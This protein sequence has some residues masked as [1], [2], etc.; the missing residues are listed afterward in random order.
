[1]KANVSSLLLDVSNPRFEPVAT[2]REAINVLLGDEPQ[3]LIRLAED[4]VEQGRLSPV[5]SAI[6]A[7][8]PEGLTV[9]EGNRRVASLKLLANPSLADDPAVAKAFT[10]LKARGS[11]PSEIDCFEF[12]DRESARHW[13][14]VRHTGLN[15]GVGI[16]PWNATQKA[17]FSG[18]RETQATRGL[19]FIDAVAADYADDEDVMAVADTARQ[20]ITNVGR[21]VSDPDVRKALGFAIDSR[22]VWWHYGKDATRT[23]VVR[24]LTDL[25]ERKVSAFMT[26]DDRRDYVNET[27]GS[28]PTQRDRLDEPVLAGGLGAATKRAEGKA[29]AN[30]G[31]GGTR[32]ER[33]IFEKVKLKHVQPRIKRTLAQSQALTI[34][35]APLV[36]AVMLR[37]VLDLVLTEVGIEAKWFGQD[38]KL[39]KKVTLAI[40]RLDPFY[41]NPAKANKKL[42]AAFTVANVGGGGVAVLDLNSYVHNYHQDVAPVEVRAYSA[43]FGPLVQALDDFHGTQKP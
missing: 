42:Q 19:Q 22:G 5:E 1:M 29:K 38:E 18:G 4:I 28:A 7:K 2:Q 20:R 23:S 21:V 6:V 10:D 16:D 32:D 24:L 9:L 8:L 12:A 34:D 14:E 36:T 13:I 39:H 27:R 41:A 17:R 15:G 40:Q 11:F 31:G 25:S 26:K 30:R 3:K 43:K 37:V 33:K 35:Q